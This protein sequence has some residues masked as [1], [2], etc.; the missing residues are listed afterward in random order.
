[1]AIRSITLLC[2]LITDL[3]MLMWIKSLF[4]MKIMLVSMTP[5]L[6]VLILPSN[7]HATEKQIGKCIT[8]EIEYNYAIAPTKELNL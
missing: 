7:K 4:H 5:R 1:M 6:L 2:W 3:D 8:Y